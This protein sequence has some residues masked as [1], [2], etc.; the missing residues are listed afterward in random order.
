MTITGSNLGEATG[1]RFGASPAQSFGVQ[2]STSVTAVSPAGT[3]TVGVTVSTPYGTT[4][5]GAH[6]QFSY[7]HAGACRS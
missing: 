2:S 1:V 6:E 5:A 4:T 3:G 7:V